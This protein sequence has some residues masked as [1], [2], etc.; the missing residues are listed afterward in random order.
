MS[1]V[2]Y[3]YDE[4]KMKH[5]KILFILGNDFPYE[6]S[7]TSLLNNLLNTEVFLSSAHQFSVLALG[8]TTFCENR[9][10]VDHVDVYRTYLHANI[11][12]DECKK[13]ALCNPWKVLQVIFAKVYA[14]ISRRMSNNAVNQ[15]DVREVVRRIE[16]VGVEQF[17]ILVPMFGRQYI[18]AAALKIKKKYPNKRVV[19][20]QV[21]PCA[22]NEEYPASLRNELSE[23]EK[24]LYRFSDR[25]LTTPILLREAQQKYAD[26]VVRKITA[27]EFPNVVPK[28][29]VQSNDKTTVRKCLYTGS[30][31]SNIRDPEYTFRLFFH[32]DSQIR[33]EIV[34][35]ISA[36]DKA[37]CKK[38]EVTAHG[39]KT[40]Q[41]TRDEIEK[42]HILVNIGNSM[43]NQVPSKLFEYISYG[44]PIVNICKNRNC[45]TLPYLENYPYALNLFEE[46]N[47]IEEQRAK[48]IQF[49]KEN[50]NK[51]VP[52]DQIQKK[53]E[54]CTP[55]YCARQMMN[56]FDEMGANETR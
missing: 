14:K 29:V 8:S 43:L 16:E 17:D 22:S 49:V 15:W 50:A 41:E 31:Y 21:D 54:S 47:L 40:L 30:L 2:N 46:E 10:K 18:A 4:K 11:S 5:M 32:L 52:F 7:C 42:A 55:Q 35:G 38:Y 39:L 6:G 19:L 12:K 33:L 34:G 37:K 9:E 45:S 3:D 23:F 28:A 53:Y 44:K 1:W 20:Y 51:S 24:E 27:M 48:L 13:K 56:A 25:I 26:E 36:E